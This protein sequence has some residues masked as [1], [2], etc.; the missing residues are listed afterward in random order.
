MTQEIEKVEQGGTDLPFAAGPLAGERLGAESGRRM[1]PSPT[2]HG[3]SSSGGGVSGPS[4]A[5][6]PSA[7]T[8]AAWPEVIRV[9]VVGAPP[10]IE[11]KLAD[12]L[13][14]ATDPIIEIAQAKDAVAARRALLAEPCDAVLLFDDRDAPAFAE[15]V[16]ALSVGGGRAVVC[17]GPSSD[18]RRRRRE[19]RRAG[20]A[21]Y[22]EHDRLGADLLRH[23]LAMSVERAAL[24]R[25]LDELR[26]RFVLAL[27]SVQDGY[28]EWDIIDD[29]VFFSRRWREIMD[30]PAED[31]HG[32]LEDWL[33]LVHPDDRVLVRAR[34]D[35]HVRGQEPTFEVEHRARAGDGSFRWVLTRGVVERD[36]QGV[37]LRMAGSLTDITQFRARVEEL[38]RQSRHDALTGL[39][40]KELFMERLAR[41]VE[42]AREFADAGF[43]VLLVEVDRLR[44]FN[45]SIGHSAGDHILSQIA[46]RLS[47][48][49][50]RDTLVARISGAKFAILVE[51]VTDYELGG[52]LADRLQEAMRSPFEVEGEPV[53]VT[54][55]VGITS[56][57][58]AYQRPEEVMSD[59]TTA[60]TRAKQQPRG[61]RKRVFSTQ[62]RMEAISQMRME[63]ALR[64]AVERQEFELHYQ[65]IVSLQNG[66]LVGFEALI[67][68]QSPERGRISPAEFIPIAETTGL[69]QPIGRWAFAEAAHQLR[70]WTEHSAAARGLAVSVNLSGRQVG[71]PELLHSIA[72]ALN[73]TEIEPGNIKIELTE[74]VLMDNVEEMSSLLNALRE[75]GVQIW[76]DDFGTGYSSLSYLHRFPVDG[77]KV[78]KTFVDGVAHDG[79]SK[80][81]VQTIVNLSQQLGV[82]LVAEGIETREQADILRVMGC[83]SGQGY[84]FGRPCRGD[85]AL[86]L[87]RSAE[88]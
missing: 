31:A 4:P 64:Q 67:R 1:A 2:S 84:L 56:S 5:A 25:G 77:L 79:P 74:S 73:E 63:M 12:W 75:L 52:R 29:V 44:R 19:L 43:V 72:R 80:A 3:S 24:H 49:V 53:Y 16:Q 22:L 85:E 66:Y 26:S 33:S 68:W 69:I 59:A 61:D 13:R 38:R 48:C 57:Q 35:A 39:P 7:R 82:E 54:V 15:Q 58:R 14:A 45:E 70:A 10:Q 60:V 34:L 50:D 20:V 47:S 28:W 71:D 11:R 62:M 37:A 46:R 51:N 9:M 30:Y 17:V 23:V 87:I 27:R 86:A 18:P 40:R 42:V 65:P 32:A 8:R 88:A 36:A 21:A 6:G 41:A 55:S 83:P 78:D 81:M 76:V